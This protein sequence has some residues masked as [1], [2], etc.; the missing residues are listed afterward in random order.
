MARVGSA[1]DRITGLNESQV[2]YSASNSPYLQG[3]EIVQLSQLLNYTNVKI[4][5]NTSLAIAV[6]GSIPGYYNQGEQDAPYDDK[7]APENFGTLFLEQVDVYTPGRSTALGPTGRSQYITFLTK[8]PTQAQAALQTQVQNNQKYFLPSGSLRS[9]A[10]MFSPD[11]TE[12]YVSH[13]SEKRDLGQ[14]D[15]Y[16]NGLPFV[17]PDIVEYYPTVML[18]KDPEA[19][20]LPTSL[21]VASLP[22]NFDGVIEVFSIRGVAD[23]SLIEMPYVARSVKGSLDFSDEK[24]KSYSLSDQT[25]LEQIASGFQVAPFLDSVGSF[26]AGSLF[27]DQPGAFSDSQENLAPFND[28][29]L[30]NDEIYVDGSVDQEIRNLFLS[31][32]LSGSIGDSLGFNPQRLY[33]VSDNRQLRIAEEQVVPQNIVVSRHGF[34]FSQNDNY[35]YDSIAFGGLKK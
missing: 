22:G 34:T 32:Y 25:D 14:S 27:L 11:R 16:N 33:Y 23:R 15:D 31:R 10:S 19:V 29:T 9:Q 6:S 12:T 26:G 7:L 8:P 18:Q 3:T 20:Q 13:I 1:V 24:N 28:L 4:R 21:V 35:G 5:S 30:F 17:E 2:Y